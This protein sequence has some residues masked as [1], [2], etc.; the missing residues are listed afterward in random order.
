M[1]MPVN[2]QS[3]I[4][5]RDIAKQDAVDAALSNEIMYREAVAKVIL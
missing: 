5:I 4:R 2:E 1:D 3:G